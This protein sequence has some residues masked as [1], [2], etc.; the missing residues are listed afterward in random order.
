MLSRRRLNRAT[1]ARQYLLERAPERAIDAIEHLAGMQSQAPLA[2]YVGLW[3]RLQGFAP[4]ELSALTER[5]Q[6][7]RLHLMRNT[8]HLVSARDCLGWR[9]LSGPLHAAGFRAHF[10][11]GLGDAD[12]EALLEQAGR[13][14][15]EGATAPSRSPRATCD[16]V[17]DE[18]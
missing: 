14:L 18:P 2:P 9:A 11:D 7:V 3:T 16:L 4:D 10:R 13:L 1:P 15:A 17:L 6:V 12:R 5:R 8:V